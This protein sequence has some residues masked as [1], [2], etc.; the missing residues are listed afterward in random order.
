MFP[1]KVTPF[2][3]FQALGVKNSHLRH[4]NDELVLDET[5]IKMGGLD[6]VCLPS[7][8]KLPSP[9]SDTLSKQTKPGST[10]KDMEHID[11]TMTNST[12]V[13]PGE[14]IIHENISP[15]EQFQTSDAQESIE[16]SFDKASNEKEGAKIDVQS[17]GGAGAMKAH[18]FTD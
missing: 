1:L 13:Y 2:Q 6:E 5:S 11:D 14:G 8:T 16:T 10:T 3:C 12:L 17:E 18:L 9:L 4:I 15:P 7:R